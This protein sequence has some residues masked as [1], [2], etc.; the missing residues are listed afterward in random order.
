MNFNT[1]GG[2]L[3]PCVGKQNPIK[4]FPRITGCSIDSN[5]SILINCVFKPFSF[6][7]FRIHKA[8]FLA[9]PVPEK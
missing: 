2:K 1:M 9:F 6:A 4:V 5:L 3:K 8:A 7:A